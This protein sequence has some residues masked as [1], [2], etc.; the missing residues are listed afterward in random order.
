MVMMMHSIEPAQGECLLTIPQVAHRL[1]ICR[2]HVYTL[3]KKVTDDR[4]PVI[5]VGRCIRV[6]TKTLEE[7]IRAQEQ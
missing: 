2:A 3:I 7:W 1:G 6:S 5:H 4:L